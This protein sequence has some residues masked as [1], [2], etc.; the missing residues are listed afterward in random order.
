MKNLMMIVA[1]VSA[2][3]A[4]A[5]D[6]EMELGGRITLWPRDHG[7]FLFVDAQDAVPHEEVAELARRQARAFGIDCRAVKGAVPDIRT[8]PA[9]LSGLGAKGAIWVI[10]DP[11]Y[12]VSLGAMESGWGILNVAPALNEHLEA[13]KQSDLI[14][15]LAYRLFASIHGVGDSPMMPA[16]VMKHAVGISGIERLN[17]RNFSPEAHA[18]VNAY[19]SAA[20][21]KTCKAGTYYEACIAGWAPDPT[22][23]VQK[24]IWEKVH[25]MPT[26]PIKILPPSK[27]KK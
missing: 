24:A 7:T 22:N 14:I 20:G 12:P 16:C 6:K 18:K 1:A 25:A 2:M 9:Q 5:V 27:Q 8:I 3:V 26:K 19:L 10:N 23:A 17:C 15:K 11:A 4:V 21:Y 13:E